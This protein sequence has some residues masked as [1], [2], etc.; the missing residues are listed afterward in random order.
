MADALATGST[1]LELAIRKLDWRDDA[2][3]TYSSERPGCG[4]TKH[5]LAGHRFLERPMQGR[6]LSVTI[7]RWTAF[8]Q[9][10]KI[11]ELTHQLPEPP[12]DNSNHDQQ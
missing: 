11:A 2:R 5:S 10:R 12:E 8:G 9:R 6:H 3:S 1:E 4:S 7:S